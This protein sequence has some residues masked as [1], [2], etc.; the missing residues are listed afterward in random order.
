MKKG[1]LIS[2]IG[3]STLIGFNVTISI[4]DLNKESF[5][6]LRNIEALADNG[7]SSHQESLVTVAGIGTI[8]LNSNGE[9][10]Y[11]KENGEVRCMGGGNEVCIAQ[12]C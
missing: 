9:Y 10:T 5:V 11:T 7:E 3:V 2:A 6:T 8:T 12:N 4:E 1:L